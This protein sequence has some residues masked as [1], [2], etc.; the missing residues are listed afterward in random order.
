MFAK[1]PMT[2]Q[3]S[4]LSRRSLETVENWAL[5]KCYAIMVCIGSDWLSQQT[6]S[7]TMHIRAK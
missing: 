1:G 6:L 7:G 3:R 5:G 4:P 2:L